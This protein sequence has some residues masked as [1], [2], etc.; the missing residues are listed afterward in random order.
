M[1]SGIRFNLVC[2]TSLIAGLLLSGMNLWAEALPVA[3]QFNSDVSAAG[4]VIES[5]GARAALA[6]SS[7]FALVSEGSLGAVMYSDAVVEY[8]LNPD[9]YTDEYLGGEF[10]ADSQILRAGMYAEAGVSGLYTLIPGS[11]ERRGGNEPIHTP[12]MQIGLGGGVFATRFAG[13]SSCAL[14]TEES[15]RFDE[16][17]ST[18]DAETEADYAVEDFVFTRRAGRGATLMP[19]INVYLSMSVNSEWYIE[20]DMKGFFKYGSLGVTLGRRMNFGKL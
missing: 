12:V 3:L 10:S 15:N 8:R 11:A 13:D 9:L 19:F 2:V 20:A 6:Q 17:L 1:T 14:T 16:I 4:T 18:I 5:V 7:R